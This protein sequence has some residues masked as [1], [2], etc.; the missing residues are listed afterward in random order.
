MERSQDMDL[1]AERKVEVSIDV[2]QDRNKTKLK[3][4]F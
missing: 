1:E 2:I 4:V 3:E